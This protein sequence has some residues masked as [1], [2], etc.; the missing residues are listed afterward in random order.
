M[1]SHAHGDG[2]GARLNEDDRA[3]IFSLYP[4]RFR[5]LPVP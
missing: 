4:M 2:R 5:A 1:R 3:G